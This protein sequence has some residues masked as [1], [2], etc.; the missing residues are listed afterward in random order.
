MS[1][2]V[3]LLCVAFLNACGGSSSD[4]G[5][6]ATPVTTTSVSGVV[7]AGPASGATVT[8]KTTAGAVV[9]TSGVPTDASGAFTVAIPTTSLSGDLIFETTGSGATF[10]DEATAAATALGSLSAFVPAGTLTS[11][12]NV[13]LDPSSTIVQKLVAGGKTRT[14]AFTVYSSSFGY[15]PD[16]TIKPVFANAS[17]AATTPQRLAGFR[18]AVFSQL[19]KDVKDPAA[20]SGI[21]GAAKQ[22]ELLQALADDLS[23]GV[24]DGRKSGAAV[25]TAANYT[26]PE[27]I[28]N[29]YNAALISF[30]KSAVNKSKLTAAQINAPVSGKTSLTPSYKVEYIAQ[31]GG[32]FVSADTI[33]LKI[34]RRSDGSAATGLAS[35]IVVNPYMVMDTMSSGANWPGSVTESG[36]PGVYNVTV[37]Y[38]METYWGLDMYWK[39][40]VFIG[41]ET[42]YFYPKVSALK[43][44]DTATVSFYT[45]SDITT[46]TSKRRYRLWRESIS[47]GTGG[48]YDFT[49]FV[50][51]SDG[52][53]TYGTINSANN[54]PVYAGRSWT[55]AALA[56]NS[57]KVQAYDGTTWVD[58][59][60]V[61]TNTGKFTASGLSL[62]A[63]T[64]GNVYV[65]LIINGITY[66]NV[67]TGAAWDVSNATT[68]NAVQT[69]KVTP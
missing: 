11:G 6:Y 12:S 65:R 66:T 67:N 58:L 19:T 2:F 50:S 24:L 38:S 51:T 36:T 41:S 8:V 31:A 28:L 18:A 23:D 49:V 56:I 60:P 15:K 61:G 39:L 20:T 53:S 68:S 40:Y 45:S 30:Q 54:Y 26:I 27:D 43:N 34:T 29:Q 52:S 4:S 1:F 22:F 37:R 10:T 64:Q 25:K 63:G 46:G 5:S 59:T 17:T 57:V 3:L 32:D 7:F 35:S 14:A 42:A 44:M 13:T 47:A 62:T 9:A 21:G 48:K 33:Q 55:T 69:F 16:F